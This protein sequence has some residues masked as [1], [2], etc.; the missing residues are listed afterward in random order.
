MPGS[1]LSNRFT[2]AYAGKIKDPAPC[3]GMGVVHPRIRGEDSSVKLIF[4]RD[5]GSPPHT[6]GRCE[7]EPELKLLFGFTP[8]Y[9]GKIKAGLDDERMSEVHPRIRGE[10]PVFIRREV[11]GVGSPP[12]TR[13]KSLAILFTI[14]TLGSPPHTRGRSLAIL[15][16]IATLGSP[17]HTRGR[18]NIC[19]RPPLKPRFTPAYAGKILDFVL[20]ASP[21]Q[22]HPRI[23]GEDRFMA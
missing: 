1:R 12:H 22:V 2:P 4:H 18:L 16:T 9:A 20:N 8:A 13:G 10:D 7:N 11:V 5:P 21:N 3:K 19:A 17:P 14:A 15:F 23:R 6:R